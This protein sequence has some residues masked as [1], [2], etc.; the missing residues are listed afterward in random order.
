MPW[1][2]GAIY[3]VCHQGVHR[4]VTAKGH[5]RHRQGAGECDFSLSHRLLLEATSQQLGLL[6]R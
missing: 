6:V 5:V 4:V 2:L 1:P 3:S